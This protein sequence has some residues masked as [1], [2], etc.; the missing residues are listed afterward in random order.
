MR[1]SVLVAAMAAAFLIAPV[2]LAQDPA[3]AAP[4]APPAPLA[5]ALPAL[6]APAAEPAQPAEPQ[7]VAEMTAPDPAED[8]AEPAEA[9]EA[10]QKLV[11]R[12]VRDPG[13]RRAVRK[14]ETVEERERRL[15]AFRKR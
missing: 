13:T 1:A 14:C 6:P 8:A 3:P 15:S 9:E 12:S 10:E 2:A 5:P 7:P 11:C 4:P